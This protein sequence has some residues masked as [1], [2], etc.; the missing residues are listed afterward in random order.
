M[1]FYY[2]QATGDLILDH[3]IIGTGYSGQ[4]EYKNEPEFQNEKGKGCIPKG[5]YTIEKPAFQHPKCGPFCLR[6][7]PDPKN[8]MY[9][10]DGFLIHGDSIKEPGAAS[11][12]CI[13]MARTVREQI[14][15]DPSNTLIVL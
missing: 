8:V 11:D 7:E 4:P 13:I 15:K 6:L 3:K 12:G 9:G 14:E 5:K 2:I 1:S 10:R